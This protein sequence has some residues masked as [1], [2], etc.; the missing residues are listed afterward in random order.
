[1]R[2]LLLLAVMLLTQ[3][4]HASDWEIIDFEDKPTNYYLDKESI[5]K[6][7]DGHY[8]FWAKK[9]VEGIPPE[10]RW[11]EGVKNPDAYRNVLYRPMAKV[12]NISYNK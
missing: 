12:G 8:R 9:L 5:Q 2:L 11:P 1:M 4:V 7:N 3:Y 6:L 10:K